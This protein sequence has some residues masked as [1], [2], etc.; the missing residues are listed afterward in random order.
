M[1]FAIGQKVVVLHAH[2]NGADMEGTITKKGEGQEY[3]GKWWVDI[4]HVSLPIEPERL[5]DAKVHY[6]R[7][8]AKHL[9]PP[10][11]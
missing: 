9:H 3:K 4:G 8:R 2:A 1:K 10:K 7:Q 6:A 5:V 11:S